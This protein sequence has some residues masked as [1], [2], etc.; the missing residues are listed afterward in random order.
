M[1][2]EAGGMKKQIEATK[3]RFGVMSV[4]VLRDRFQRLLARKDA[5]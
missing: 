1:K 3:Q 2:N 5:F 4:M